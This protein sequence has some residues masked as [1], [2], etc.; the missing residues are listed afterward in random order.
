M[1]IEEKL[2]NMATGIAPD[3]AE[4]AVLE[5]E[6]LA[7]E[8]MILNRMYPFGYEDGTQVPPRYER[9]Q[10]K[11]AI[12]LYSQRGAEGQLAHSEN[13]INRSWPEANRILKQIVPHC[14]SVVTKGG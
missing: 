10:I 2:I 11:L 6:L 7:A 9:L 1:T 13:G 14:G 8:A 12:E 5:L 3:V 4:T